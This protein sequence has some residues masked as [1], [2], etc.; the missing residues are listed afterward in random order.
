MDSYFQLAISALIGIG[1]AA[2]CGF[3]VFAPMLVMSMAVKAHLL[4]LTD[5]WDWIGSWPALSAFLIATVVEIGGYY[6]PWIDNLLDTIQTPAAIVAGTVATAACVS[7]MH[8]LVQWS[9]AIIA[10]VGVTG[11]IQFTT[12]AARATSSLT[13]G[14]LANWIV[15]TLE[16]VMAFL[17]AILAIVVPILAGIVVCGIGVVVVRSFV[18]RRAKKVAGRSGIPA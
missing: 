2:A 9:T 16:T 13:T 10:G 7:E 11:S 14:G 15:A 5:G 17:M 6:L 4:N 8:P 12:V 1:L 18:R 3:K